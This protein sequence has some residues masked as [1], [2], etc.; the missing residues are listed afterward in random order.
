MIRTRPGKVKEGREE[1]GVLSS[2]SWTREGGEGRWRGHR[3]S[4]S[5]TG[6]AVHHDGGCR[7]EP[8]R[9]RRRRTG[10]R[11]L[12]CGPPTRR[13][14]AQP[15][16]MP[17][18]TAGEPAG[19]RG[20][21]QQ[22]PSSA[23]AQRPTLLCLGFPK[24]SQKQCRLVKVKNTGK[25]GTKSE[26]TPP[27]KE[28]PQGFGV[29]PWTLP[30]MRREEEGVRVLTPPGEQTQRGRPHFQAEGT[31]HTAQ[32]EWGA[33]VFPAIQCLLPTRRGRL[34]P[35]KAGLRR[36][37]AAPARA[38]NPAPS[39][40]RSTC[41]KGLRAPGPRFLIHRSTDAAGERPGVGGTTSEQNRRAGTAAP[42]GPSSGPGTPSDA[43]GKSGRILAT[44]DGRGV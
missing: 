14:G 30:P 36:E 43:A 7:E 10:A 25:G 35:H 38:H 17:R 32:G 39:D 3:V 1:A 11:P 15:R 5:G 18:A 23:P 28:P 29:S 2:P 44:A 22:A 37:A 24:K 13:P 20:G 21:G 8:W 31:R 40:L 12:G 19:R 4:H 34:L 41:P 33:V 9:G 16:H 27:P 6:C 26:I 42:G